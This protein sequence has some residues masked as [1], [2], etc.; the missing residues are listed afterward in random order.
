MLD[1][2]RFASAGDSA[3]A[4]HVV[5][6]AATQDIPQFEDLTM[7][8]ASYSSKVNSVIG[9]FGSYDMIAQ[10]KLT[11]KQGAQPGFDFINYADIFTGVRCSDHPGLMYFTN[12]LNF[13]SPSMPPVLI[14]A[15]DCDEVAPFEVSV[16]LAE[17]IK[18]VCGPDRVE[19]DIFK[20]CTHGDPAFATPENQERI[21]SF[22]DKYLK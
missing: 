10:S 11:D 22:L 4:Y 21:F 15:G 14:Q 13:I 9:F 1:A 16:E 19:F 17:K 5:M 12:V 20:G 6:A 2:S 8:N 7:G 18:A 3:G